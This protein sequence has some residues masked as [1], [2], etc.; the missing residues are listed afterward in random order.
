[1]LHGLLPA[2]VVTEHGNP[3]DPAQPLFPEEAALVERA[4]EKR[5]REFAKGREC[6][7]RALER[8]GVSGFP[9]L[10]GSQREPLWPV[11]IAGSISHTAG[12]CAA[13]ACDERLY[14]TLGIDVEPA[15]PISAEIAARISE[16]HELRAY[17]V[18]D[19][20][21]ELLTAR[22]IFSAK[23]AVYKCQ[24]PISRQ[25]VGFE[26]VAIALAPDGTFGVQWLRSPPPVPAQ[27]YRMFGRWCRREGFLITTAWLEA[28]R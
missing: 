7:R 23:E 27:T 15:E 26:E 25:F 16:P 11:G 9:I 12:L 17:E 6:A 19:G 8:L 13:I 20:F 5:R 4:V 2:G 14:R 22:L 28:A 21:D 18:L 1:M 10:S 3:D 24:F